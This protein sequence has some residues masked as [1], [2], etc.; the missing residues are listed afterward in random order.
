MARICLAD[1][2]RIE[3]PNLK[4]TDRAIWQTSG[5]GGGG[6][7][8]VL[9]AAMRGGRRVGKKCRLGK[10]SMNAFS[11]LHDGF[12]RCHARPTFNSGFMSQEY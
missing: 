12:T 9:A 3:I 2:M 1:A 11:C 4:M 10:I 5:G 7:S 8:G 6:G